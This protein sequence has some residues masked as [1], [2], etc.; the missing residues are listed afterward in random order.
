MSPREAKLLDPN[1][2][3]LLELT[4]ETFEDAGLSLKV[5]NESRTGVFVGVSATDYNHFQ[6][7]DTNSIDAHSQTGASTSIIANRLSYFYNLLGPSFVVDTACSSSLV[8]LNCACQSIRS[9]ESRLALVGAVN[10]IVYPEV[11]IGFS[12]LGVLSADG[13]CKV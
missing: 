9:T 5:M 6:F 8:A 7:Q 3:L 11:S 12:K 2:R 4:Y 1:Q 10:I 13:H